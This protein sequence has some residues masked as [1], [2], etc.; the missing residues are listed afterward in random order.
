MKKYGYGACILEDGISGKYMAYERAENDYNSLA[1]KLG[2]KK[3]LE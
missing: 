3:A 1:G 2:K